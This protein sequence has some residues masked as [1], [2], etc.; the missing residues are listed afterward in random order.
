[1]TSNWEPE[2]ILI[3]KSWDDPTFPHAEVQKSFIVNGNHL[4]VAD[5]SYAF[6]N[7][8][9]CLEKSSC[10]SKYFNMAIYTHYF[11]SHSSKNV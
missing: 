11:S 2:I 6:A 4:A 3:P 10:I 1:L 5:R 9:K 8:C 7:V